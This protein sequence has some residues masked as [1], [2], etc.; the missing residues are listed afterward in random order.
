MGIHIETLSEYFRTCIL[1]C[2]FTRNRLSAPAVVMYIAPSLTTHSAVL[3]E[4]VLAEGV[5][6]G[7]DPS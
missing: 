6:L 7:T 1:C 5:D 2:K 3:Q 4:A